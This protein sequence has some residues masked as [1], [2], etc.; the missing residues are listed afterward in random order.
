MSRPTLLA[1]QLMHQ[2][3]QRERDYERHIKQNE[4]PDRSDKKPKRNPDDAPDKDQKS[5]NKLYESSLKSHRVR[6]P[7]NIDKLKIDLS[8]SERFN[9]PNIGNKIKTAL[10]QVEPEKQL[11]VSSQ[12]SP[13][14][15]LRFEPTPFNQVQ[16]IPNPIERLSLRHSRL[17]QAANNSTS[18]SNIL[19]SVGPVQLS[20]IYVIVVGLG[21]LLCFCLIILVFMYFGWYP[22]CKKRVRPGVETMTVVPAS[23]VFPDPIRESF[24]GEVK[25]VKWLFDRLMVERLSLSS[26][27]RRATVDL[28]AAKEI[29]FSRISLYAER[30]Y[31]LMVATPEEARLIRAQAA[32]RQAEREAQRRLAREQAALNAAL[33]ASAVE[34]GEGAISAD[35][36]AGTESTAAA[37]G[38]SAGTGVGLRGAAAPIEMGANVAAIDDDDAAPGAGVSGL[39][40]RFNTRTDSGDVSASVVSASAPGATVA[41]V[42]ASVSSARATSPPTSRVTAVSSNI[43]TRPGSPNNPNRL[44]H[45]VTNVI[46]QQ[47]AAGALRAGGGVV[48]QQRNLFQQQAAQSGTSSSGTGSGSSAGSASTEESPRRAA[49]R[50]LAQRNRDKP[51][52]N[53]NA[54]SSSANANANARSPLMQRVP[55]TD[56]IGSVSRSLSPAN[57]AI[58]IPPNANASTPASGSGTAVTD[59]SAVPGAVR[60]DMYGRPQPSPSRR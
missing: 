29:K 56:N 42:T 5:F 27:A 3:K 13:N 28:P 60:T 12:V 30:F 15:R 45:G 32:A 22:S 23:A 8:K 36:A 26:P 55:S 57:T 52:A 46:G 21:I 17:L 19:L 58:N 18:N 24:A 59:P 41:S 25:D 50:K 33:A 49:A 39:I 20:L 2:Q 40:R 7:R 9:I 14:R 44:Q 1:Q 16:V 35:G 31:E 51:D 6:I 37:E 53:A 48:L 11:D 47:Q 34:A 54:S 4:K 43:S 38:P 10:E